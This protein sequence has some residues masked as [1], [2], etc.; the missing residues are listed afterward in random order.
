M[1]SLTFVNS[2]FGKYISRKVSSTQEE[3]LEKIG[4]GKK[5]MYRVVFPH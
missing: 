5:D 2:L 3:E 1:K 4:V